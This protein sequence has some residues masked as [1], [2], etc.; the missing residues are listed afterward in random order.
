MLIHMMTRE[1]PI[2][3]SFPRPL[4]VSECGGIL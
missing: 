2:N 3:D 4:V 1:E